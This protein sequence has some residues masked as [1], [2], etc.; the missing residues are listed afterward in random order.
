MV[1]RADADGVQIFVFLVE[2]LA[3]VLIESGVGVS[4]FDAL[5]ASGVDIGGGDEIDRRMRGDAIQRGPGHA[6]GAERGEANAAAGWRGD[7]VA[8]EEGGGENGATSDGHFFLSTALTDGAGADFGI[9]QGGSKARQAIW[10]E[11]GVDDV[12]PFQRFQLGQVIDRNVGDFA[13]AEA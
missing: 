2:H 5:G 6:V 8:N 10:R 7:E 1:R 12:E 3:P 9:W 4:G 11:A 13:V